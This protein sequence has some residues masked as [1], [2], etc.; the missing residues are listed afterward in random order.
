MKVLKSLKEFENESNVMTSNELKNISGGVKRY[1][2]LVTGE[3]HDDRQMVCQEF[4][5]NGTSYEPIGMT[6]TVGPKYPYP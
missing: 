2:T 3:A 1:N 5:F 4:M 6:T